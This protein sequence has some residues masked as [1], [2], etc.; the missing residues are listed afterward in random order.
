MHGCYVYF[1][2]VD[3]DAHCLVHKTVS[4]SL[5]VSS[6]VPTHERQAILDLLQLQHP[7]NSTKRNKQYIYKY[8]QKKK[9]PN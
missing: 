5:A 9:I 3:C 8:C 7:R 4:H 2:C 6:C 1:L